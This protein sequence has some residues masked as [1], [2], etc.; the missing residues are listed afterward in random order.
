M[1]LRHCTVHE[2]ITTQHMYKEN[3]YQGLKVSKNNTFKPS[4]EDTYVA[5][6][7]KSQLDELKGFKKMLKKLN[8]TLLYESPLAVNF[9]YV[10]RGAWN[11]LVVFEFEPLPK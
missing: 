11:T 2:L 6:F 7:S 3:L 10:E 8:G 9:N 1:T 4:T 5:V